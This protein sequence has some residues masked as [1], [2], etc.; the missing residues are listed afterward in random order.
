MWGEKLSGVRVHEGEENGLFPYKN[1][2][3]KN[4][5]GQVK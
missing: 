3:Y 1:E 5:E 2:Y 4:S